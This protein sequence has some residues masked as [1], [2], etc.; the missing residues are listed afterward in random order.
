MANQRSVSTLLTSVVFAPVAVGNAIGFIDAFADAAPQRTIT[1]A[2]VKQADH[3]GTQQ[4]LAESALEVD[5]A[6]MLL[7][8]CYDDMNAHA[9][10]GIIPLQTRSRMRRD[11]AY[12]VNACYRAID[13]LYQVSGAHALLESNELQ[14]RWRDAHAIASQPHFHWDYEA[15]TWARLR[16]GIEIDHPS[17]GALP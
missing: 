1:Q 3:I 16:L 11:T 7:D 4:R 5:I 15:E 10:N 12:A 6:G 17:L 13:R 2:R 9:D 8:R 14:R